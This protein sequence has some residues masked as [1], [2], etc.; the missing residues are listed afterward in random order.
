MR[1]NWT[2]P[3]NV[4][5]DTFDNLVQIAKQVESSSSSD[6]VGFGLASKP[7]SGQSSDALWRVMLYSVRNPA[8]CDWAHCGE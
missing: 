6:V 3:F 7:V 2:A 4:A 5:R 8:K 1:L